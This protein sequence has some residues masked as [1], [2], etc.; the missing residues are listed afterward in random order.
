[1]FMADSGADLKLEQKTSS[2]NKEHHHS[3]REFLKRAGIL[4]VGAKLGFD[5]TSNIALDVALS[6]TEDGIKSRIPSEFEGVKIP[7]KNE[8]YKPPEEI[9]QRAFVTYNAWRETDNN[10]P[11]IT[12][13]RPAGYLD[14]AYI[15]LRIPGA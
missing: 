3:R 8:F 5:L 6:A 12:F 9:L 15:A 1:M 10:L 7:T 2:D 13:K 4:A 11:P 14:P